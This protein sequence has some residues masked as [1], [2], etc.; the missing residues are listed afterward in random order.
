MRQ[1]LSQFDKTPNYIVECDEIAHW[2][3]SLLSA[4]VSVSDVDKVQWVTLSHASTVEL[5]YMFT[6]VIWSV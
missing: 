5:Q 1:S 3:C 2:K 4:I 6:F